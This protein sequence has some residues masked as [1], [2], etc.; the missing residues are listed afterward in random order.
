MSKIPTVAVLG[1]NGFV[2]FRLVEWLTFHQLANVR[3]IVRSLSSLAKLNKLD[4]DKLDYRIADATLTDNLASQLKD[5]EI[6]FHCVVGD[7]QTILKS[8]EAAYRASAQAGVRRLV[9][10]SSAVVHGHNPIQGTHDDSELITKQPFEYNVS[11]VMSEHLL[12]RLRQDQAVEVV[13]LRPSIVF[14]PRSQWFTAQIASDLLNGKAYLVDEGAGICNTVYVD[15][16]V[17]A[18]WQGAMTIEAAN[19]DFIITDGERVTWRDLYSAVADAINVDIMTVPTLK[20]EL[21]PEFNRIMKRQEIIKKVANSPFIRVVKKLALAK[22]TDAIE[23]KFL[24]ISASNLGEKK[25]DDIPTLLPSLDQEIISLQQCQYVLPITK[26]KKLL[27][28]QPLISFSEGCHR[29][30]HW[31]KFAF[32]LEN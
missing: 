22:I 23:N 2:G 32:R 13:T 20:K 16:L 24:Q 11:K 15:N 17:A 10:L 26:A 5:C 6:L 30:Q 21:L 27:G 3:P 12:R 8:A 7:R 28:Y 14:G 9:Y 31:I 1:A 19:Q 25:I 18:M 29:T 4:L